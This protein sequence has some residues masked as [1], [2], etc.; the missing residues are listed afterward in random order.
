[1]K[2]LLL[3]AMLVLLTGCAVKPHKIFAPETPVPMKAAY[4]F[5]EY[6]AD[7]AEYNKRVNANDLAGAKLLRN[8]IAGEVEIAIDNNYEAYSQGLGE[9]R[10]NAGLASDVA[11]SGLGAATNIATRTL[12]KDIFSASGLAVTGITKSVQNRYYSNEQIEPLI[13]LMRKARAPYKQALADCLAKDVSQC[14]LTDARKDLNA[15]YWA[16][17]LE[18]ARV[19]MTI[20]AAQAQQQK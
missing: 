19:E 2:S 12:L 9:L 14:S 11:L 20:E 3:G 17:T 8:K 16:G 10:S 5:T 13:L 6:T 4:S 18:S 7:V 15:L 1:M